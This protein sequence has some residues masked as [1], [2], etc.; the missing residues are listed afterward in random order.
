[1]TPDKIKQNWD[2]LSTPKIRCRCECCG[3]D[4]ELFRGDAFVCPA[5][6]N[7]PDEIIFRPMGYVQLAEEPPQWSAWRRH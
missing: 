2:R 1:M 4:F 7:A 3:H 5:C 6:G